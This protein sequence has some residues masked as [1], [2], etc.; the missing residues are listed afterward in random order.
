[1]RQNDSK[2]GITL[3]HDDMSSK[4]KTKLSM[5]TRATSMEEE[6][7]SEEHKS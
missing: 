6:V 2:Q 5:A 1:M 7:K 4:S 3:N